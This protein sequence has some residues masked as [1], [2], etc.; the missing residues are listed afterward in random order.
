MPPPPQHQE[1]VTINSDDEDEPVPPEVPEPAPQ[2]F[3]LV[4][5]RLTY[6]YLPQLLHVQYGEVFGEEIEWKPIEAHP[7]PVIWKENANF[8]DQ[9]GI[10]VNGGYGFAGWD[11]SQSCYLRYA[12]DEYKRTEHVCRLYVKDD[13]D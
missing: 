9:S 1:A 5:H 13:L 8:R 6:A 2:E 3:V 7:S 11:A 10:A 12:G 4:T